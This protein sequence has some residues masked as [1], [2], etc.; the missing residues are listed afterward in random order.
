MEKKEINRKNMSYSSFLNLNEENSYSNKKEISSNNKILYLNIDSKN[1]LKER[2]KD[3]TEIINQRIDEFNERKSIADETEMSKQNL[4]NQITKQFLN[5]LYPKC[6]AS[7]RKI[8]L[9]ISQYICSQKKLSKDNIEEYISYF[10]SLRRDIKYSNALKLTKDVFRKIGYI[11]CYTYEKVTQCLIKESKGIKECILKIIENNIDVLSDFFLYCENNGLNYS[12]EKKTTVW[13]NLKK[14]YEIPPELI[15]L[16]NLFHRMHIL[17]I[18]IEFDGENLCEED[19][20]LFS[21]T[22]LNINFILPKLEQINLN[23]IHNKLQFSLYKRY[24]TKIFNLLMLSEET[25]KRNKIKNQSLMYDMKWDFENNFNLEEYRKKKVKDIPSITYDDYSILCCIDEKITKNERKTGNIRT[26]NSLA[27]DKKVNNNL[28]S[29]DSITNKKKNKDE[30]DK[31]YKNYKNLICNPIFDDFEILL[32]DEFDNSYLNTSS[33]KIKVDKDRISNVHKKQKLSNKN[34]YIDLLEKNY[35][36]FDIML[37]IICGVTRIESIKKL[38]L[39]SNEFYNRDLINYMI[40]NYGVDIASIDD[41]FHVL[42]MLYNKMSNITS[43]LDLLNIEINSLDILSFDK[44]IGIIYKNQSL[45]TLNLS[46]FSSDVS[47]FIITLF[48]V[49]EQMKSIEEISRYVINK[50]SNFTVDEFE[51]KIVNDISSYFADNLNLLFEIIKKKNNLTTLGLNF[52]LPNILINNNNYKTPIFKLILNIIFLINNNESNKNSK[53]TKLTLLSPYTIFD[54]RSEKNIDELF[55]DINIYK[56]C[57]ELKELNLQFQ[58]YNIRYIKNL[59]STNLTTL[60]IGDLDLVSFDAL[61][62]YLTSYNFSIKSSLEYLNI[63]ILNKITSFNTEIKLILRKLFNIKIKTLSEL[64][65]FSNLIINSKANYSYLIKILKYNWIPAY[66]IILNKES[67]KIT[68]INSD[69]IKNITFLVSGEL[70]KKIFKEYFLKQLKREKNN[71]KDINDEI[72]WI[73]KYIFICNYSYHNLSFFEVQKLSFTILQFLYLTSDAKLL[74][75]IEE[76][77]KT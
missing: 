47:Y 69:L 25:I 36:I 35:A 20:K 12:T 60:S 39:I 16:I 44:I 29:K 75:S 7:V 56:N 59:I 41:E 49:Y 71:K 34:I 58:F 28:L 11:F 30:N 63:K 70:E 55:K 15:F 53:I 18:N 48:K 50:G 46:L 42:D 32:E 26:F 23:F 1:H 66:T 43:N 27:Y 45:N 67:S 77:H 72:F 76:E 5:K 33:T 40:I 64:K 65:L 17:D 74:H 31:E 52:D 19:I 3:E 73:L 37:M 51:E 10:Y 57:T 9:Q 68:Y 6:D 14:K 62:N 2:S 21:I 24:Y 54:N 13:K 61:V 4:T 38:V 22:L 8:S